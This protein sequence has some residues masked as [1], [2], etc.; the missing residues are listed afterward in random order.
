VD[1]GA[2]N[3]RIVYF[4]FVGLPGA[5]GVLRSASSEAA[6]GW[7]SVRHFRVCDLRMNENGL[8]KLDTG[9][10]GSSGETMNFCLL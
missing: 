2:I 1:F 9:I 6:G 4:N 5:Y 7:I 8:S 3:P 10:Q